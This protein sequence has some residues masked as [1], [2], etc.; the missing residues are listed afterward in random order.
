MISFLWRLILAWR[1]WRAL[2]RDGR[3]RRLLEKGWSLHANRWAPRSDGR[4]SRLPAILGMSRGPSLLSTAWVQAEASMPLGWRLMALVRQTDSDDWLA[5]AAGPLDGQTVHGRGAQPE[6]A[7]DRLAD[8]VRRI[9]M[10][11][12]GWDTR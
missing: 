2:N 1:A 12:T 4:A 3:A 6:Q 5:T 8:E 11:V 9:G 7:L 10:P